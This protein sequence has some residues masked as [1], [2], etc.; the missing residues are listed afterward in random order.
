[1]T[2]QIEI[3]NP[4]QVAHNLADLACWWEGFKVG[5]QT[6]GNDNFI[7]AENGVDEARNLKEKI[8]RAI[9]ASHKG[10]VDADQFRLWLT[11]NWDEL[12]EV[13]KDFFRMAI[14]RP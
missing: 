4:Q 7:I 11:R 13:E 9:G 10:G 6:T 12:P 2:I 1:M 14:T 3:D 8:D 5:R